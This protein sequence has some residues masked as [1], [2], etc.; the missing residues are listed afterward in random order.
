[1]KK[2][3]AVLLFCFAISIA[4]TVDSGSTKNKPAD[5]LASVI[6]HEARGE[7]LAGQV[8]V[9]FVAMNRV[10]FKGLYPN[11][12]CEVVFQDKQFTGLT[13]VWYDQKSMD[14]A[15]GILNGNYKPNLF[16]ATHYHSTA[17]RPYW[18]KS[19]TKLGKIGKHVFYRIDK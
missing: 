14:V 12:L 17:V 9:G 19:M 13:K 3:L 6:W 2:L 4:G 5:C 1:M 7:P 8:A 18:S 11:S 10:F 15:R 16:L